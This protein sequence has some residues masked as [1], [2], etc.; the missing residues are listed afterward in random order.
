MYKLLLIF[1]AFWLV[2]CTPEL[3]QTY[4]Q[5]VIP[6]ELPDPSI[7]R[8]GD[9]Y[10]ASGS[11]NN[12]GP[13]YPIYQSKDLKTW[14][15]VNYVFD[16][17]PA[18][19]IDSY[20]APELYYDKGTFYCYYTARRTDGVSCIGVATTS[21]IRKGFT[22]HGIIIEWGNEAIDA[23]VYEEDGTKYITWKAYG[24]NPDKP[25][26]ILGSALTDDGLKL[27]GEAFDILTAEEGSWESGGIEGQCIVKHG[28]Y[29]YMLYSGNACCGGSCDYQVGVA[30]AKSML[31]PWEKNPANPILTGNETWKC[32]GHGTAVN[33]GQEWQYLYHAYHSYGFPYLG[34]SVMLSPFFWDNK[35]EWPYFNLTAENIRPGQLQTDK[36]DEFDNGLADWWRYD[37][38]T[39]LPV[40]EISNSRLRLKDEPIVKGEHIFSALVTVPERGDFEISTTITQESKVLSGLVY[41]ATNN[42]ALGF[43]VKESKLVVWKSDE[44]TFEV[45][46]EAEVSTTAT[47]YLRSTAKGA[48][49]FEFAYS[50]DNENWTAMPLDAPVKAS[51]LAWWSWGMKAGLFVKADKEA[52]NKYG[53]FG[54][55][56]LTYL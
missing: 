24:L 43:G 14:E 10:Y 44:D 3:K 21:D 16:E 8:V 7:I 52:E 36:V 49:L 28:D 50:T 55:F 47:V 30:R 38:S 42:K 15:F 32:P 54:N 46:S 56:R 31:G 25:I 19:T 2:S 40:T 48:N 26:Q 13:Y 45:L 6:G 1:F 11:S 34:R 37:A 5:Q 33:T 53:T 41:Y 35:T 23:Y 27:T 17:K 29:L 18:W 12:W 4:Q 20:W 51:Y 39:Y 9:M 22:D